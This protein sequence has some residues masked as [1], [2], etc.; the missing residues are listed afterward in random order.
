MLNNATKRGTN[1]ASFFKNAAWQYGLQILKYL[2]P[3]V[4]IPYLTRVLGTETYAVYAYVYSFMGV[5]QTIADFGFT[6]SGTKQAVEHEGDKR[7][8][9][10]LVGNITA[11]R[12]MLLAILLVVTLVIT[13]FIP[14]MSENVPYV[15]LALIAVGLR[16]LLPD[17]IFQGYE[18]M[19]P[20]TTRYFASKGAQVLLTLLL[21][22]ESDDLLLVAVA[23]IV[24]SSIG[25]VWSFAAIKRMFGVGILVPSFRKS[26]LELKD[27]AIY[28]VSNV[29]S[30]LF[31]GFTTIIIGLAL[32]DKTD[33]AFWSLTLTTVNA[34]QALYT[35][36]SN[37]LYPHM[38]NSHDFGFVRKLA[39]AAV[40]VLAVGTAAYCMLSEPIMLVLGGK[41][42]IGAAHVMRMIAPVLP[43]S[44][45]SVLIGWPVL[46]PLGK[47]KEL[48]ASTIIAGVFNVAVLL[49]IYILGLATLDSICIVRW[50]VEAVLLA[51]RACVILKVRKDENFKLD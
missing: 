10:S 44:F 43:L 48:T 34:V 6:L 41:D 14:I 45:Y 47:V 36:I 22:H 17:F 28:C 32:T 42:Y 8:L 27:S 12:L 18:Q 4:L 26:L 19:G 40:P 35:P 30:S 3:L 21:V 20:L 39:L 15:V 33:I 11:A 13:A 25:L 7:E 31:S 37:S 49:M 38:L 1:H 23:D 24:G 5:M 50:L 9:S 2:F 16:A 51:A 46:G 29:S